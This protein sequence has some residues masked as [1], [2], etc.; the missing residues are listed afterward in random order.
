MNVAALGADAWNE[1]RNIRGDAAYGRELVGVGGADDEAE[2]ARAV[3]LFSREARNALKKAFAADIKHLQFVA[4]L[5]RRAAEEED[6]LLFVFEVG[7]NR[8]LAHVGRKRHAVG[9]EALEGFAGVVLGRGADVAALSIKNHGNFRIFAVNAGNQFFE[10][11][12]RAGRSKVSNLRFKGTDQI[13]GRFND[14]P[15]EVQDGMLVAFKL[16]RETFGIGV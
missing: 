16:L 9:L 1:E 6:A 2:L 15:A 3:P 11:I 7:R 5:I 10:L 8:V 14:V 13:S 12:F 4:A